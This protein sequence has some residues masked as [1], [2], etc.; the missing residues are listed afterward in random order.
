MVVLGTLI[1][2]LILISKPF[3]SHTY[4]LTHLPPKTGS[5]FKQVGM[6]VSSLMYS[7]L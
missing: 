7:F 2:T 3:N 5:G 1:L 4:I 6:L